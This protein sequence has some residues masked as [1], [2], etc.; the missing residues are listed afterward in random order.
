TKGFET[1]YLNQ[2]NRFGNS[3]AKV[4]NNMFNDKLEAEQNKS[5][6]PILC[7]Y[8]SPKEL[9]ECFI[10]ILK[11]HKIPLKYEQIAILAA[12]RYHAELLGQMLSKTSQKNMKSNFQMAQN[13]IYRLIAEKTNLQIQSIKKKLQKDYTR[14]QLKI[15]KSILEFFRGN[16]DYSL[17]KEAINAF[18]NILGEE[19]KINIK[20]KLFRE[21]EQ[22]K[23]TKNNDAINTSLKIPIKTIHDL[24]GQT[25]IAN[26]VFLN[27]NS[28]E[29]YGFLKSYT[30]LLKRHYYY[31]E[32][33]KRVVY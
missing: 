3:I 28:K 9:S 18:F 23:D 32:I 19:T 17:I 27:K 12:A 11:Q 4:L 13:M 16:S 24:K 20:N 14:Y 25:L 31:S 5:L 15:N 29:E 1:Y 8:K 22:L 2:T 33:N 7:L 6:K 10:E 30:S 26:M 21:L